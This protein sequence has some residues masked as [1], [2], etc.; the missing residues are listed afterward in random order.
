MII[1]C[2]TY[3]M[4]GYQEETFKCALDEE[5]DNGIQSCY[6]EHT[7]GKLIRE[8]YSDS[9]RILIREKALQLSLVNNG[10]DFKVNVWKE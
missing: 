9:L 1:T 10:I 2:Y 3:V 7:N 6:Q 4:N 5:L 8:E